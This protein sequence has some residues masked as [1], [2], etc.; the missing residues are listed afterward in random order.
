MNDSAKQPDNSN[1]SDSVEIEASGTVFGGKLKAVTKLS[2]GTA[3]SFVLAS[4]YWWLVEP[5]SKFV[6]L[7]VLCG[8]VGFFFAKAGE[9]E[10]KNE[11]R[12]E[13]Q[14]RNSEIN[15]LATSRERL[16]A[17]ILKV[18]GSSKTKGKGKK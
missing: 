15:R 6:P 2:S 1:A 9:T 4:S 13:I 17:A 10:L 18:R 5:D 14:Y 3:I 11:L 8:M 16:E 7:A 12:G